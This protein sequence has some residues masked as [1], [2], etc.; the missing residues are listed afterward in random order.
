MPGVTPQ[1]RAASWSISG[2]SMHR[3]DA[4]AA[5]ALEH[6]ARLRALGDLRPPQRL[7]RVLAGGRCDAMVP[8]GARERDHHEPCVDE[9]AQPRRDQ[10]QQ[11]D[12]ARLADERRRDLVQRLELARPPRRG[13]VQPR[14]LDR[15]RRLAR[16][17]PDELLVVLGEVAAVELL[18]Q[19]EVPVGDV[20]EQHGHAEERLHRRMAR[21]EADRARIVRDV[22]Q[23][24]RRR[25]ADEDAEDAA[26]ARQVA[27]LAPR[28]LVDAGRDESLETAFACGR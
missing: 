4:L 17:Q 16:E 28:R 27:D 19:V 23:P 25:V 9:L 22:V 14:V 10:A 1:R 24:Q 15:D 20:A 6:G 5:P 11:R 26:P 18:R 12:E 7:L 2:S 13:L 3:V 8:S 21:R